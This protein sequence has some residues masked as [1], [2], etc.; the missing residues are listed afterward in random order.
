MAVK[1]NLSLNIISEETYGSGVDAINNPTLRHEKFNFALELDASTTPVV[2]QIIEYQHTLA[3]SSDDVDFTALTGANGVTVDL[4]G[5]RIEVFRI[6]NGTTT[7][8]VM[9]TTNGTLTLTSDLTNGLDLFG[10]D[11]TSDAMAAGTTWIRTYNDAGPTVGASAKLLRLTGTDTEIF[12]I[13]I[14]AG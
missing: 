6:S 3:G 4:T 10:T 8:G 12:E 13:T 11:F 2:S 14:I 1:T 5:L 7:N 9:S